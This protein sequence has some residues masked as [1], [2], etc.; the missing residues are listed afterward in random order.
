M[1]IKVAP[2]ICFHSENTTL[3]LKA[4]SAGLAIP[5]L[6]GVQFFKKQH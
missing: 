5:V 6:S 3:E 4:E 1:A 2:M